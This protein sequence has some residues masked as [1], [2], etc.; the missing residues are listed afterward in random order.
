[1]QRMLKFVMLMLVGLGMLVEASGQQAKKETPSERRERLSIAVQA[2]CPVTGE[3]LT[4]HAKPVKMVLAES[5]E[6]LY[7]CCEDCVKEKPN[8]KHLET[9]RRNLARAQGTCLVMSDNEIS[10]KSKS[11]IVDG[12][13]VYVCCPPCSKKM[14][15][16]P[17]KF[18]RT[19]DDRYEAALKKK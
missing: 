11:T 6:V 16:D 5:K 2:I 18:L 19:L 17:E 7:V 10:E 13:F 9:I 8:A 14:N 1:M 15:A 12:R 4:G 3:P